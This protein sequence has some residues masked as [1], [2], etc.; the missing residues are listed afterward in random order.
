MRAILFALLVLFPGAS[1]ADAYIRCVQ[2]QLTSLGYDA[3][4]ASGK[5]TG[6]TKAAA[7]GYIAKKGNVLPTLTQRTALT[8]CRGLGDKHRKLRK[9][10]PSAQPAKVFIDKDP[11]G[12]RA[13]LLAKALHKSRSFFVGKFKI[14]PASQIDI[15]GGDSQKAIID[16]LIKARNGRG[17]E[18]RG[19]RNALREHCSDKEKFGGFEIRNQLVM[20]WPDSDLKQSAWVRKMN[21]VTGEVMVHEFAHHVQRELS[22]DKNARLTRNLRE[23]PM[24]PS[25][26]V[27]GV[28]VYAEFQFYASRNEV[29]LFNASVMQQKYDGPGHSL[30]KLHSGTQIRK[31]EDAYTLAYFAA[32]ILAERTS[33]RDLFKFWEYSGMGLSWDESFRRAYGIGLREFERAFDKS[34][35]SDTAALRAFIRSGTLPQG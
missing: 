3:G 33:P 21:E 25:W 34:L 2:N 6:Q 17:D 19:L 27:E 12:K 24:G 26:L 16:N 10:Q 11:D 1:F 13:A 4:G 35:R 28:A 32:L 30:S 18:V 14:Y 8:W 9:L 20:C 23:H 5:L 15:V 22:N 31:A 7:A 29:R